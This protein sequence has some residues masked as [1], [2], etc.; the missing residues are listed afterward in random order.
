MVSFDQ[1]P[2]KGGGGIPILGA[3]LPLLVPI[4]GAPFPV[5]FFIASIASGIPILANKVPR[6]PPDCVLLVLYDT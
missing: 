4:R 1:D 6:N 5:V 3:P 2:E